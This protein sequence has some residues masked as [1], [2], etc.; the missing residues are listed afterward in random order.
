[1]RI[2]GQIPPKNA[3]D[4]DADDAATR[5][6]LLSPVQRDF[7]Q[8]AGRRAAQPPPKLLAGRR[9][10][11]GFGGWARPPSAR[12]CGRASCGAPPDPNHSSVAA[13]SPPRA[14]AGRGRLPA[15]VSCSAY[16]LRVGSCLSGASCEL[17]GCLCD[18]SASWAGLL[19]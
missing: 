19:S 13:G 4:S 5:L 7:R 11:L 6:A 14:L 9:L 8:A 12:R 10:P 18:A 1:M 17:P 16:Y 3:D 2:G 15:S